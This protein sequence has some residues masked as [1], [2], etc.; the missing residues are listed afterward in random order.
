MYLSQCTAVYI[1]G[2]AGGLGW[3]IL[4]SWV[5]LRHY[6]VNLT[7]GGQPQMYWCLC[8][9]YWSEKMIR[10]SMYLPPNTRLIHKTNNRLTLITV[11]CFRVDP[12]CHFC[13]VIWNPRIGNISYI[14]TQS[15]SSI[16]HFNLPFNLPS[17]FFNLSSRRFSIAVIFF[18]RFCVLKTISISIRHKSYVILWR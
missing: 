13:D 2:L 9:L 6:A 10:N 12:P 14:H 7:G 3:L 4:N 18:S 16:V 17:I 1:A 8:W 15:H 11:F 5:S